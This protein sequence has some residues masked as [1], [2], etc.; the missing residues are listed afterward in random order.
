M[1]KLWGGAYW[2]QGEGNVRTVACPH[3]PRFDAANEACTVKFGTPLRKCVVASTEAHL[4]DCS[5]KDVLEIGYGRFSLG[6]NLV[7]RS[8][9]VWSGIEPRQPEDK[10]PRLGH[11]GYGHA[12]DIRFPDNTFDIIYGIQTMEH[13]GQ[14]CTGGLREPSDYMECMAEI[15]RV[16]K[17]GG[18]VYFDVPMHFHGHEMFIMADLESVSTLFPEGQWKNLVLEKWRYECDPLEQYR[19]YAKL[20]PEWAEEICSYTQEQVEHAKGEP[21]HLL[22]ITAEKVA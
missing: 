12:A 4:F 17:P 1:Q 11:G 20:F 14:K 2:R 3:C 19:P 15:Y 8:G 9:G 6:K 18:Q 7:N 10:A 5:G 21:I 13:W 22:A 16:L